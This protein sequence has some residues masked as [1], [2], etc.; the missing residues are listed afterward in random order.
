MKNLVFIFLAFFSFSIVI[1]AQAQLKP[2]VRCIDR[3]CLGMTVEAVKKNLPADSKFEKWS[4]VFNCNGRSSCCY[5]KSQSSDKVGAATYSFHDKKFEGSIH[6]DSLDGIVYGIS[7]LRDDRSMREGLFVPS[8]ELTD[9]NVEKQ[10]E[11]RISEA[12][13][14]LR[15]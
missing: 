3:Y 7:L 6:L 11:Q 15:K 12:C 9:K 10:L 14:E 1:Y 2:N 4:T 5:G 8:I 13:K